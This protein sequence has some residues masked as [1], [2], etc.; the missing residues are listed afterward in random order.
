MSTEIKNLTPENAPAVAEIEKVCFSHPWSEATLKSEM[1]DEHA[2][3]FGAY[4]N[5]DLAGYIGGRTLFGETEIFNVAVLPEFRR[6]GLAKALIDRFIEEARA[7]ETE[8]IF[9]EVR[10]SNLPAINLYEKE[11]F[12]FCGIR[13]NY[14]QDPTENAILMHIAYDGTMEYEDDD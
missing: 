9:L 13:K 11:G 1:S 7:K 2:H 10:T 8:K 5:G 4:F 6:K 12:V 14:Y 3:F